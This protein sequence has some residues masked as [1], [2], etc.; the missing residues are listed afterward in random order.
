MPQTTRLSKNVKTRIRRGSPPSI[1]NLSSARPESFGAL[2]PAEGPPSAGRS[3]R[4]VVSTIANG[5][6]HVP[7]DPDRV[8]GF[9]ELAFWTGDAPLLEPVWLCDPVGLR[10]RYGRVR[11]VRPALLQE[12]RNA[13]CRVLADLG[14]RS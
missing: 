12:L 4:S 5:L 9:R 11:F 3:R 1:R 10:G 8:D 14:G 7:V 6:A 2:P 13:G